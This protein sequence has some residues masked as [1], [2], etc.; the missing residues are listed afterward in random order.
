MDQNIVPLLDQ[1]S[2]LHPSR[3]ISGR[4]VEYDIKSA[5]ITMLHKYKKIN[6]QYFYYLSNLPKIDREKEIGN[7]IRVDSS[8]YDTI[9]YG[10]REAKVRLFNAN[11]IKLSEIVRI[12]NDAVYI[13]R[14]Y[15]LK[16]IVFDDVIFRIK[17]VNSVMMK[18]NSLIIFFYCDY[19]EF[20]ID[21]KGMSDEIMELHKDYLLSDLAQ[22]IFLIEKVSIEEAMNYF[23]TLYDNYINMKLPKEYYRCFDSA[24]L[25][26]HNKVNFYLSNIENIED[27]DINYNLI[28]LRE[29]WSILLEQYSIKKGVRL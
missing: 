3:Y 23:N 29:L 5:N 24:S 26:K 6:D 8:V 27:I 19:D 2:Y 12:A 11:D 4:I 25:Y 16:N 7:M 17:S 10:I 15:D 13:N 20:N 1:T 21:I 9:K 14:S 22:I 18:L 28:L